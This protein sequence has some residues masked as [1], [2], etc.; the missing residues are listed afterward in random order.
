MKKILFIPFAILFALYIV[1]K[2]YTM[3][4]LLVIF[5]L[6]CAGYGVFLLFNFYSYWWVR[7]LVCLLFF[8]YCKVF[9]SIARDQ[10][11]RKRNEYR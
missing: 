5:A 7:I 11:E 4:C 3:F 1:L 6:F 10:L 8:W 2:E 9:I